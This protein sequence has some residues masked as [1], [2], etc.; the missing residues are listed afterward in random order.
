MLA[1][2]TIIQSVAEAGDPPSPRALH[3]VSSLNLIH[4]RQSIFQSF[5][6]YSP[7]RALGINGLFTPDPNYQECNSRGV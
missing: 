3:Y 7:S 1:A 6:R 2:S 4:R 5:S